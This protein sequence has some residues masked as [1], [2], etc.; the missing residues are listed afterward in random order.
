M[1]PTSPLLP[2]AKQM[3]VLYA[4]SGAQK[5]RGVKPWNPK[6]II[7]T[8]EAFEKLGLKWTVVE[9]VG[10]LLKAQLD[11]PGKDEAISNFI[12]YMKNLKEYGGVNVL[13]YGWVP[14]ISWLRTQN[15]RQGRG[16]ALVT[17]FDRIWRNFKRN[18]LE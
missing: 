10:F 18:S 14:V 1:T 4:V 15:D 17:A 2:Y 9:G 7:N 3:D 12:T 13:G 6:A 11:L 5:G 16:G 8:R